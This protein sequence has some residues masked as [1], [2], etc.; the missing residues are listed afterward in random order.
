MKV[1]TTFK[2]IEDARAVHGDTYDYSL[3]TYVNNKTKVEVI[4]ETHESFWQRPKDHLKGKACPRCAST[5]VKKTTP[6]F[7][8]NAKG[9]HGDTYAYSLV[10][11]RTSYSKVEIIC[12]EHGSFW[13]RPNNHLNGQGC[14]SCE[15]AGTKKTTP[16]FIEDAKGMHGNTYDYSL[17]SYINVRT[18]IEIICKIHGSFWQTPNS[19]LRLKGCPNCAPYGFNPQLPAT[20]YYLSVKQGEAYKIGITNNSV[21][22]RYSNVELQNI[23]IIWQE[24]FENGQEAYDKEQEILKRYKHLKYEGEDLLKIGNTELFREDIIN[25]IKENECI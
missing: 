12:K 9:I 20:L 2:F 17:V 21:K 19:H 3:V 25:Y 18:K 15:V 14:P 5:G 23:T 7:I 16:Q 13:Q 8:K 10:N 24:E 4:C 22:Q 1:K 11:Y 6:Q